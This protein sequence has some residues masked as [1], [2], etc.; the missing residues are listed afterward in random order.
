LCAWSSVAQP[1]RLAA[2]DPPVVGIVSQS[3]K[4]LP[5][6]FFEA[7]KWKYLPWPDHDDVIESGQPPAVPDRLANIPR[8]WLE[9]LTSV[10][11]SW[12]LMLLNQSR[13][14]VRLESPAAWVDAG[15]TSVG[16]TIAGFARTWNGG[17]DME[18]GIAVTGN[19][20]A[21]LVSALDASSKEWRNIVERHVD[22][23]QAAERARA[24]HVPGA[25]VIPT[26]RVL[27]TEL[28][29]GEVRLAVIDVSPALTYIYFDTFLQRPTRPA[30]RALNCDT[31]ASHVGLLDRRSGRLTHVKWLSGGVDSCGLS[32]GLAVIGAVK[33]EDQ[34][35][36]VVKWGGDDWVQYALVDPAGAQSAFLAPAMPTR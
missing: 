15:F 28:L 6:A 31:T 8:D 10:P 24:K 25:V 5:L 21:V 13:R 19:A 18:G 35:R 32:T 26:Q 9:P 1:A 20:T 7:G 2:P 23:F 14:D 33:V 36:V 29:H 22:A 17:E 30:D 4:L 34:L 27:M 12:Q 11:A 3:G 16:L